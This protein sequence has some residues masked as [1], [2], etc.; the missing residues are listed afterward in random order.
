MRNLIILSSS[1]AVLAGHSSCSAQLDKP[2][3]TEKTESIIYYTQD[4]SSESVQI[5]PDGKTIAERYTVPHGF[6]REKIDSSTFEHYLRHHPLHDIDYEVHYYDGSIKRNYVYSSVIA[7]DIDPFDLQQCADAVMRLRGEYLFKTKQWD[8]LHFNFLSDGK[9][10]SFNNYNNG[11]FSYSKFRKYMK[12][13]FSYANTASLKNELIPVPIAEIQIGD[14]FIQSGNPYGHAI[15][16]VD[17]VENKSGE[18]KILL[19]QSY[20]P[21]QETHILKK[22]F[23][24]SS[25]YEVKE[26][27]LRTPEWTF[28]STDL[29]RFSE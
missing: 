1:L 8:L 23:S 26:G 17:L 27:E 19:A 18:K 13:I 25:W 28:H 22:N 5:K 9:P 24:N 6:F 21:A 20:M 4:P 7:Q 2:I 10:R 11:D 3:K 16:V 12:Y 14:I 29:R 15:I